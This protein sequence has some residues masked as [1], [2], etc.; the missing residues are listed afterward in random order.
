MN[1]QSLNW[2]D[3]RFAEAITFGTSNFQMP[4]FAGILSPEEI[5]AVAAYVNSL[6]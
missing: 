3:E 2:T 1:L 4:S 5:D 6:N